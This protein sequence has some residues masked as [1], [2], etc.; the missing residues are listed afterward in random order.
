MILANAFSLNMVP[1][2]FTE[3]ELFIRRISLEEAQE[4]LGFGFVSAVG[5]ADTARVLS[6]LLEVDVPVARVNVTLEPGGKIL[7]AQYR[8]PRLPEGA[9]RLPEGA[10]FVFYLVFFGE[11]PAALP[12]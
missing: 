4:I 2:D 1:S 3:G 9:S 6:A 5:H 11:Q 12:A 8:G 7:V 10:E